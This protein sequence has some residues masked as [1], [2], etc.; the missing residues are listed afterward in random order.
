MIRAILIAGI[1]LFPTTIWFPTLPCT[2]AEYAEA[3]IS[4][5]EQYQLERKHGP[6]YVV[7]VRGDGCF[8]KNERGITCRWK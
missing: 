6:Y 8:Y 2:A 1:I 7:E 4:L 5:G 3:W